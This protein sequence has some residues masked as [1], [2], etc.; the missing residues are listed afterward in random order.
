MGFRA[1][2]ARAAARRSQTMAAQN[3]GVQEP[4]ACMMAAAPHPA[5]ME[6]SPFDVYWMP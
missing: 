2:K 6:A 3:T 1:K 5:K 4:Y